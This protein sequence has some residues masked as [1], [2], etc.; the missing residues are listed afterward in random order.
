MV[1][2]AGSSAACSLFSSFVA[3]ITGRA[4]ER[5]TPLSLTR[6]R[7]SSS[8]S[9]TNLKLS[10]DCQDSLGVSESLPYPGVAPPGVGAIGF[11]GVTQ[12]DMN[13]G[14]RLDAARPTLLDM[15]RKTLRRGASVGDGVDS[16]LAF[17]PEQEYT[18][19]SSIQTSV[20]KDL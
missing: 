10:A 3:G 7:T 17:T 11:V 1:S 8:S 19:L 9:S 14:I 6:K 15:S 16:M 5:R 4:R 20:S 12:E 18:G 13:P 2:A